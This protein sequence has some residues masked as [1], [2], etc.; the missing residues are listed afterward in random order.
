[1]DWLDA[2]IIIVLAAAVVRGIDLGFIRQLFSAVGFLGGLFFG[3]WL[4]G[5]LLHMVDTVN[6]RALVSV[7]II[8]GCGLAFLALA[9]ML[10]NIVK[11]RSSIG[12]LDKAD[13]WLGAGIAGVTLLGI[14]WLGASVFSNTPLP[15]V[16]QQIRDSAIISRLNSSMPPAPQVVAKLGHLISPNGFPQ[17]FSGTE[18]SPVRDVP[19]P[20]MGEMTTAVAKAKDST[21]KI[22]GKGCGGIVSGSGFVAG[23]GLVITNAHVVAGVAAPKVLD[24]TG[25]HSAKVVWFNPDMDFAVLRTSGLVGK[26]LALVNKTVADGTQGVVLGYPGGGDFK[27]DP[28]GIID[29][30]T[31]QGKNI[32]NQDGATREIYSMNADIIS[33]NSGG[34]VVNKDGA[35]IGIVFAHSVSY[36]HV[37]YA[38]TMPQAIAELSEAAKVT[39]SVSTG[40]CAP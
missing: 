13:R 17:V 1:M 9:E 23:N 14:V 11:S 4:E 38:L 34:P 31:A 6:S 20:D 33:G 24:K 22:E 8:F 25:V 26:P 18:P 16:Q 10:A 32:Y 21:V 5:R 35:V 39:N 19:V 3:A 27:A 15:A 36:Q 37:G 7:M 40:S 2:I 28:M 29:A 30:F 12:F